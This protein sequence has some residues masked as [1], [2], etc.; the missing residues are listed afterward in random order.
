MSE[1]IFSQFT[2]VPSFSLDH[3][4]MFLNP[5]SYLH[6]SFIY[7]FSLSPPFSFLPLASASPKPVFL[8][9]LLSLG[10]LPFSHAAQD[11]RDVSCAKLAGLWQGGEERIALRAGKKRLKKAEAKETRVDGKDEERGMRCSM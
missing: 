10:P 8:S 6:H 3:I 1:H 4:Q 5:C 11:Y 7:C 2:N 9:P